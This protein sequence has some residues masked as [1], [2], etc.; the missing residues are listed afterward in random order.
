VTS[1]GFVFG[2]LDLVFGLAFIKIHNAQLAARIE[3]LV[4]QTVNG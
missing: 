3:I 4:R 2:V 1:F